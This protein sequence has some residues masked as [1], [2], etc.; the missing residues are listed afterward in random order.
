MVRL[1]P[2]AILATLF[3]CLP[4]VADQLTVT[5]DDSTREVYGQPIP[6]LRDADRTTFYQ[7]RN[8]VRQ[9]WVIPPSESV[10]SAGL[11]PLYNRISCIACHSG[12]GRGFAPNSPQEPMRA[13]LVRLSIPGKGAHGEPVPT[14]VYGD[15]LNE[16]GVPSVPAE[17]RAEVS[18]TERT[19]TL[20][21]GEQVSLRQ[22]FVRILDLSYGN[23][24]DNTMTSPRIA[25][26]LYGLGLL[27]AVPESSIVAQ[28]K[29]RKP[30]GIKGRI[31]KVW[32]VVQNKSVLGRFGWKANMPNLRQQITGAF[33]GDMGI[34]SS[35]FPEEN[36]MPAQ[37]ECLQS[38]SAGHPELSEEQLNQ[39]ELYHFALAA[40]EKR[41]SNMAN[42][43][44]QKRGETLF[45]EAS[46]AACHTPELRTGQFAKFP[47][48]SNKT[49]YPYTD[50]LLHNMGKQLADNR[51]DFLATGREWRTP[52]LWGVGLAKMVEPNAGFL[53]DGRA[54]TLQEAILWHGGEGAVSAKAFR[55]MTPANRQL[56]LDYLESI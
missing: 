27:E 13:M 40:P 10:G 50:L 33:I 45:K 22:P 4:A 37:I 47:E 19:V 8:L 43:S 53:H 3:F 16:H 11:G 5:T 20:R 7:G 28:T 25:P 21:G 6:A 32:D 34:T 31:N 14:A 29:V 26:A 36:C 52:A 46:C 9:S 42:A 48:I 39:V 38:P 24:P 54:R 30:Y 2:K 12:N 23:L 56:L 55:S 17:G 15:Q 41:A 35:I 1:D 51:P 18:Y 44:K 49:I